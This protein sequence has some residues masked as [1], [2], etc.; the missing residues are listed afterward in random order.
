MAEQQKKKFRI[1]LSTGILIGMILGLACGIFFGEYC[2]FLQIIGDAFIKLLQMTIL[3]YI[4]VSMILGIGS[5]TYGQAKQM[6]AKAGVLLLLF[7]AISF[8]IVLLFPLSFPAWKS[9][10]FFSTSLVELPKEVDFLNLYIPSNPFFSLANNVVP[11]VVLFSILLGVALMGIEEKAALIQGLAAASSALIRVT[12]LIVKLTP[13]GVFAITAAAAGTMTVAEFGRLQ[14]YL[15]SFNLAALLLTFGILPLLVMPVTPFK[16]KDIVGMSRDA[17]LTAFTTGNLFVVL[18]VLTYNCKKLFEK[19]GLKQEKTNTYIDVMIPISFNFPTTGKLIMLLFIMF[20][21]WFSGYHLSLSQYPTFVFSGLLSFFGGIDVAMPFMLNLMQLPYD[22]YQLYVVTGIING[23]TA[24][25]LAAMNLLV[26]TILATCALTD[27]LK[28]RM[29]KVVSYAVI[30]L[31]LTLAVIGGSRVYFSFAVKNVYEKDRIIANMQLL[32]DP[33][34]ARIHREIPKKPPTLDPNKPVLERIRETGV[35]RVG[36]HPDNLPFSYFNTV[37][38]LVG[39]DID[40]AHLLARDL[41]INLEFIPFEHD[42][43]IQQLDDH[44]V[45]IIMS[46]VF[47]TAQRLMNVR[48][49]TPYMDSTA[50]FVVKD[51]RADEFADLEEIRQMDGIMIG[52]P[53]SVFAQE[54]LQKTFP[55]AEFVPLNSIREFFEFTTRKLDALLL[56]AQAGSAWTLLYPDYQPVVPKPDIYI[57]PR[58][59]PVAGRDPGM[60]DFISQ[61]IELKKKTPDYQR[62]YQY[63]I[64]GQG[65]VEKKPRWSIIRNVLGWVE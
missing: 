46:G 63:W 1:S 4:V 29:R 13:V 55:N 60:A 23:R 17:L 52:V 40:M 51:Y 65:A 43:M 5:L 3:P 58:A 54:R 18:A 28:I 32:K 35:L 14:V 42:K 12:S 41:D 38:E 2:G 48:F 6:A 9:A 56:D 39:F 15:V 34:P 8:A 22:M 7:W 37:G 57:I 21:A 44:Q 25:L 31:L 36:Y 10:A 16:Y 49:S 61:W 26:F 59:Y 64:M 30:A 19:Y 20:A 24:T 47:V 45:D 11:A 53:K 33:A 62:L 50:A 27:T